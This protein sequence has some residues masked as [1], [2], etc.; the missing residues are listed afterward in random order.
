MQIFPFPHF[1]FQ[2]GYDL[3]MSYLV[4][5]HNYKKNKDKKISTCITL[6]KS[7]G[8]QISI[9]PL[10]FYK[11]VLTKVSHIWIIVLKKIRRGK[12]STIK[13]LIK[14]FGTYILNSP[15]HFYKCVQT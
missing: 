6:I 1:F 7:F 4:H 13:T 9:S 10:Q 8:S 11:C 12:K 5:I 15:F 14:I 2:I 3:G